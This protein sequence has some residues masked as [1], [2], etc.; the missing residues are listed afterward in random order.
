MPA[1]LG[2]TWAVWRQINSLLLYS[3][4]KCQ[5]SPVTHMPYV[6]RYISPIGYVSSKCQHY[7]ITPVPFV[8]WNRDHIFITL[9]NAGT[10]KLHIRNLSVDKEPLS[11]TCT[12][13]E[14]SSITNMPYVS[15]CKDPIFLLVS[16]ASTACFFFLNLSC[17]L[18]QRSLRCT[19]TKCQLS[20]V[21]HVPYFA[22]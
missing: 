17:Q 18:I 10:P 14:H 16:N 11:Y 3:C 20:S 9:P 19:C 15:R 1:L 4:V 5:H 13:C 21:T 7:A 2:C 6:I 22:R 12:K 8:V